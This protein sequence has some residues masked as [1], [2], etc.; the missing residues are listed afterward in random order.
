M[1]TGAF[2]ALVLYYKYHYDATQAEGT[3]AH[4][5]MCTDEFS[6]VLSI[7]YTKAEEIY[8]LYTSTVSTSFMS[9]I[10]CLLHCTEKDTTNVHITEL[11][12]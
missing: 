5:C 3:R 7:I 10:S 2:Q 12:I 8:T 1:Q 6:G 4:W 9:V 11:E